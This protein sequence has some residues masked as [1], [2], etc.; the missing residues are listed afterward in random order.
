V[1]RGVWTAW[2]PGDLWSQDAGP[3]AVCSSL[4]NEEQS[5]EAGGASESRGPGGEPLI[6]WPRK[7]LLP[8]CDGEGLAVNSRRLV[9][10]RAPSH[11]VTGGCGLV[12]DSGPIWSCS[13]GAATWADRLP[14]ENG[15][16]V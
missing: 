9:G 5:F 16:G 7:A 8:A 1:Y 13:R 11:G 14:P 15:A 3:Q 10:G 12:A 4:L 6:S 2:V